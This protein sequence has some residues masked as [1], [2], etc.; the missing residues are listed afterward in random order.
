MILI[1][2]SDYIYLPYI[3]GTSFVFKD[4][5]RIARDCDL[6][7]DKTRNELSW[8]LQSP[9]NHPS[10]GFINPPNSKWT[11]EGIQFFINLEGA[12]VVSED[13]MN[14]SVKDARLY[15][16]GDSFAGSDEVPA[17]QS[18][19]YLVD[20]NVANFGIFGG[21]PDQAIQFLKSHLL[22]GSRPKR[23]IIEMIPENTNRMAVS[24]YC[25]Y[26]SH[27]YFGNFTKTLITSS[28]TFLRPPRTIDEVFER[29]NDDLYF[30]RYEIIRKMIDKKNT[31]YRIF[32]AAFYNNLI[33]RPY[34]Y[35]LYSSDTQIRLRAILSE[36]SLA[37]IEFGFEPYFLIL[38]ADEKEIDEYAETNNV[39][40]LVKF[41][42]E[43]AAARGIHLLDGFEIFS[44][45]EGGYKG[46]Y[47]KMPRHHLTPEANAYLANR[48]ALLNWR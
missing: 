2:F 46:R 34:D 39:S 30:R 43:Q 42:S 1:L 27:D 40:R 6:K 18:W 16:Y 21:A 48:I 31:F 41:V 20:K 44:K 33:F 32:A 45:W 38:P 10:V 36:F 29:L 13:Y 24:Y 4:A 5:E 9:R 25:N 8:F 22:S 11:I 19:A 28:G 35:L 17:Q 47:N 14:I 15:V 12:R 26:Y 23:V 37:A 7:A 3:I